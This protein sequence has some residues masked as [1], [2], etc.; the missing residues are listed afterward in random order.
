MITTFCLSN[1]DEGWDAGQKQELLIRGNLLEFCR[2]AYNKQRQGTELLLSENCLILASSILLQYTRG[3]VR[4][5]DRRHNGISRTVQC[6][7]Q[8]FVEKRRRQT[9]R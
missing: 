3:T 9:Y 2:Q 8:R 6:K 7:L 5:R 1:F 4:Q